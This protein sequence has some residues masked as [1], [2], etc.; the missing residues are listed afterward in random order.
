MGC[1]LNDIYV[2]SPCRT[3]DAAFSFLDAILPNRQSTRDEY[4][5]PEFSDAPEVV[6]RGANAAIEYAVKQSSETQWVYFQNSLLT[7]PK[8]GMVV[9]TGDGGMILGVSI[10]AWPDDRKREEESI[11]RWLLNLQ[12]VT[13]ALVGYALFESPAP[14]ATV[15][16]FVAHLDMALPPKLVNGELVRPAS[17]EFEGALLLQ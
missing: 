1:G 14:S 9:F 15:E 13:D 11:S 5:F 4:W 7:E 17:D 2:L 8:I 10:D 16:E 6:I 3:A 12:F